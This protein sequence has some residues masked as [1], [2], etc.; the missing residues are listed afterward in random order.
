MG[1]NGKRWGEGVGGEGLGYKCN[2]VW[3][4][5]IVCGRGMLAFPK[6]LTEDE[7]RSTS[8][9]YIVTLLI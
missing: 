5:K 3:G 4:D 8:R 2:G 7:K 6:E 9:L 1:D